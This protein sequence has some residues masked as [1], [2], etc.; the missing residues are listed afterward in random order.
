MRSSSKRATYFVLQNWTARRLPDLRLPAAFTL[1]ELLVV[2]V[3]IG[4]L[5]A[6]LLPA[7]Q[8]AREAARRATCQSQLR[9]LG[10]SLTLFE[11]THGVYPTGGWG[12]AWVPV[13]SRKISVNQPGGWVYQVLPYLEEG[14]LFQSGT[15]VGLEKRFTDFSIP[16]CLL[17]CP[18]RRACRP[19]PVGGREPHQASPRP[20]GAPKLVSRGD[21]A[22][23]SG[24][25]HAFRWRGPASLEQGDDPLYWKSIT[26]NR[27]FTGV[28]H[29]HRSVGLR[30]VTDGTSKTYLAGEKFLEPDHYYTGG[31]QGDDDC[32]FSGYS[33][34][35]HRFAASRPQG[36][37]GADPTSI[38]FY[39]PLQDQDLSGP[40]EPIDYFRFGSAHPAGLHMLMADGS[41]H[42][43]PYEIDPEVHY[44]RAHRA[45]GGSLIQLAS[46]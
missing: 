23:N 38:V 45:D 18:S 33:E 30:R 37:A 15:R 17:N 5:V 9:Q 32:L 42:S 36:D 28:S 26:N 20:H 4:I 31:S 19:F 29:L 27:F 14:S 13:P 12:R 39:P 40:I 10:V 16:V 1:V 35:N 8:N 41:V 24:V 11:Q 34:D 22:I 6:L 3:I 21:Y 43:I 25:S 46:R 44:F 2:I 7:V